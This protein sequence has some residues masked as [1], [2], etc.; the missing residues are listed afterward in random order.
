MKQANEKIISDL[1]SSQIQAVLATLN[2]NQPYTSLM[3]FAA[4]D[5]LKTLLFAT[6][7]A[8]HK[9]QNLLT[10]PR[11]AMLIDNRSNQS[12]D[13]YGGIAIT[14]IGNTGEIPAIGR[15]EFLQLYLKKHPSLQEFVTSPTC[16]L[17]EMKVDHYY[18]VSRFQEVTEVLIRQ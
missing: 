4:T 15:E 14:A 13:H 3:A 8:T 1:F 9:Y 5:D 16:A 7:R 18:I 6:Y 12:S 10:N 17:M 2:D 11:A